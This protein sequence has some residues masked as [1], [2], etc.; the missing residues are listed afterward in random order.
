LGCE[1][2]RTRILGRFKWIKFG[3]LNEIIILLSRSEQR[4]KYGMSRKNNFVKKGEN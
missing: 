4:R 2:T 3:R 1:V